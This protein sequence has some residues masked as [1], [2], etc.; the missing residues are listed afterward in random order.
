MGRSDS[1]SALCPRAVRNSQPLAVLGDAG[2]VDIGPRNASASAWMA[3]HRMLLAAF[4]MQP[5]RPAGTAR[6]GDPRTFIFNAAVDGAQS[7]R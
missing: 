4:L 6:P 1:A 3:R 7:Y 5:D 2:G